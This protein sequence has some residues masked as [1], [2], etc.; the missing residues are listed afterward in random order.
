MSHEHYKKIFQK[1]P[2]L[3]QQM[4]NERKEGKSTTFLGAKYNVDHTV[5]IY[6]CKKMGVKPKQKVIRQLPICQ[7]CGKEEAII[8]NTYCSS[9]YNGKTKTPIKMPEKIMEEEKINLGKLCYQDYLDIEERKKY[10]VLGIDNP[11]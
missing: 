6:W 8:F 10:K 3:L 4:L 7:V 2:L 1:K 5:I 9:C 11:N